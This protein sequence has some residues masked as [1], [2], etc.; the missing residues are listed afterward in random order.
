MSSA[1]LRMYHPR[2]GQPLEPTLFYRLADAKKKREFNRKN[3][4]HLAWS[5]RQAKDK[6]RREQDRQVHF[7]RSAVRPAPPAADVELLDTLLAQKAH[8]DFGT[9]YILNAK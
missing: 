8:A 6:K 9:P 2:H 7:L 4:R 5:R 3:K 1:A